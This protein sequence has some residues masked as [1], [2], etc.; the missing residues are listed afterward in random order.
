MDTS[1]AARRQA[2]FTF[3]ELLVVGAVLLICVGVMLAMVRPANYDAEH[4]NA[5][6]RLDLAKIMQATSDYKAQTGVLPPTITAEETHIATQEQ[7][8]SLCDD[9]VPHYLKDMPLDPQK[10][11]K[12]DDDLCSADYQVYESGYTIRVEGGRVILAAPAAERGE[13]IIVERWFSIL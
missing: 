5:S 1:N 10:S 13:K 11:T 8:P 4:R 12:L 6:R 7:G 9:L 3:P 2:G